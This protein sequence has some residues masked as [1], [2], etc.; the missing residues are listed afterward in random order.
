M[1]ATRKEKK[2]SIKRGTEE[3]NAQENHTESGDLT[4]NLHLNRSA[5]NWI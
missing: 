5:Y 3:K 2:I 1:N 4:V